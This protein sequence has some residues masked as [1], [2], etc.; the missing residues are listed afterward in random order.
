MFQKNLE[1]N[2]KKRSPFFE[3]KP[4]FEFKADISKDGKY[5][6]LKEITTWIIPVNYFDAILDNK[7]KPQEA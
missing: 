2:D 1:Q 3:R 6:I 7:T 5:W 4:N